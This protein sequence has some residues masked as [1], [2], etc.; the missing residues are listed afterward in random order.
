MSRLC[1]N[2]AGIATLARYLDQATI[3]IQDD[4]R[5]LNVLAARLAS[6]FKVSLLH[7]QVQIVP[8]HTNEKVLTESN[9]A[10]SQISLIHY[11]CTQMVIEREKYE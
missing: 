7:D 4:D 5:H 10:S 3:V 9:E 6:A 1:T 8:G 11:C 2:N